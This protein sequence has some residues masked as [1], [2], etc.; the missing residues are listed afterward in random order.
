MNLTK[1][2]K[3]YAALE[4]MTADDLSRIYF[5]R[6]W[7]DSTIKHLTREGL[8]ILRLTDLQTAMRALEVARGGFI[9]CEAQGL[10]MA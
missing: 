3:K 10:A 5:N 6:T 1:R 8:C 4:P 9:L 7:V 2:M